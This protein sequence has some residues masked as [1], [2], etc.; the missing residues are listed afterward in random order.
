MTQN[1]VKGEAL[2]LGTSKME[3]ASTLVPEVQDQK[4][5]GRKQEFGAVSKAQFRTVSNHLWGGP[6]IE[7]T[8]TFPHIQPIGK[9]TICFYTE[10]VPQNGL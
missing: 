10:I 4:R 6:D 2:P 9:S 1:G 5:R 7:T 3:S 8:S